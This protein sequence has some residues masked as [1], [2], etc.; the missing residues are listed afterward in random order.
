MAEVLAAYTPR[1]RQL[2]LVLALSLL[3][4]ALWV[5]LHA[6]CGLALGIQ[7]PLLLYALMV[8]LTDMIGLVPIFV[9]NLGARELI[10]TLYLGQ[11]GV[12]PAQALALAFLVFSVKLVASLLGG[13]VLAFGGS[14]LRAARLSRARG[15]P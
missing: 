4:Q 14:E 3:F 15:D 6:V 2:A 9:N 10:F 7:A 12:A 1:G 11:I 8:P 5:A 13:L